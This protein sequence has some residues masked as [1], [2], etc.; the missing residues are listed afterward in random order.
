MLGS[1]L[2]RMK[3]PT[4]R[5][6]ASKAGVSIATVSFVLNRT[7]GQVISEK[8]KRKVQRVA[9]E[10]GYHPRAAA[11][12][13]ARRKTNNVAF[14]FHQAENTISNQFYSFVIEG[15]IRESV[16]RGYNA[17]FSYVGSDYRGRED[18]PK[19]ILER[20]A[21]G[22][23][24]FQKIQPKLLAEIQARGVPVVAID[25]YP[26]MRD[27]H[28]VDI[29]NRT[30]GALAAEHLLDLGHRRLAVLASG[31]RPS[32]SERVDGFAAAC[33]KRGLVFSSKSQR[34]EAKDLSFGAAYA[35]AL[36]ALKRRQRPTALF[37]ANDEMAAG[38]LRAAH[39]LGLNVPD[40]LSVVGFDDVAMSSYTDPPLTTVAVDK[41]GLGRRALACVV[42]LV[43]NGEGSPRREMIGVTLVERSSTAAPRC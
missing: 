43:E 39:A 8:V 1:V 20:N 11:A 18:I 6:V 12:G 30:G 22:V 21:D 36:E 24:V 4:I 16:A 19:V 29:D 31:K 35:A 10:L 28:W 40:D 15:A 2:R 17:L 7:P 26:R 25:H 9:G 27:A 42:E 5:D 13:L 34:I 41:E 37:C 3:D 14:I 38:V 33:Q 32:I 23:L